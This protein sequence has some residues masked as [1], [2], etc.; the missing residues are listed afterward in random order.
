MGIVEN[1]YGSPSSWA[2][3][4]GNLPDYY[5]MT[6]HTVYFPGSG[7]EYPLEPGQSVVVATRAINHSARELEEGDEQSPA[8]AAQERE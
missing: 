5:P 6:N 4:E 1:G 8:P 2:D 3:E 7:N